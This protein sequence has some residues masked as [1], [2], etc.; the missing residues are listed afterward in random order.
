MMRRLSE[1]ERTSAQEELRRRGH[2]NARVDADGAISGVDA[3]L[4]KVALYGLGQASGL[5]R[6]DLKQ[7]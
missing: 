6:R 3:Q 7:K 4:D 5:K 1:R 2:Q